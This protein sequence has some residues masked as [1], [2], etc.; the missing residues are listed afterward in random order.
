MVIVAGSIKK[1]FFIYMVIMAD[2]WSFNAV[3]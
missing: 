2:I 3:I 1:D